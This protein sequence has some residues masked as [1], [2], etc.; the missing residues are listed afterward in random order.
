M[1]KITPFLWFDAAA[2]EAERVMQAMLRMK[3]LDIEGLKRAYDQTLADT[4][5]Q[6][7]ESA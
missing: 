3:K 4:G 7:K 5:P 6:R 1:R 2:E